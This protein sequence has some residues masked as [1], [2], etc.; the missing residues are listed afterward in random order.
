MPHDAIQLSLNVALK[1][2]G[3]IDMMARDIQLHVA[4]NGSK[5]DGG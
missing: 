2:R 4:S 3:D 1:R 5:A